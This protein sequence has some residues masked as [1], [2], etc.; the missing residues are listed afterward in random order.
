MKEANGKIP[1]TVIRR[2][3]RG[4]GK[5]ARSEV[6]RAVIR[7]TSRG[8]EK[9]ETRRRRGESG[10]ALTKEKSWRKIGLKLEN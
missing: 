6:P 8:E 2:M 9:G 3:M 5:E 7:K 10:L 1:C 4:E